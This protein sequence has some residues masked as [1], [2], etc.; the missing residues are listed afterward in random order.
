MTKETYIFTNSSGNINIF[1]NAQ[2]HQKWY[3]PIMGEIATT[4]QLIGI[5]LLFLHTFCWFRLPKEIFLKCWRCKI[6]KDRMLQQYQK[7]LSF[8]L[9]KRFSISICDRKLSLL[10][11]RSKNVKIKVFENYKKNK[12]WIISKNSYQNLRAGQKPFFL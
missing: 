5:I 9:H 10:I 12:V 2:V 6:C 4:W 8:V 11:R 1:W 7:Q 3:Q